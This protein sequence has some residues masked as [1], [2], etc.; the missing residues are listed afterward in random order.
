[1]LYYS[2]RYDESLVALKRA[3]QIAPDKFG[4]VEG[5]NSNNYEV[6]NRYCEALAA[7]LKDMASEL[8][9]Q[10]INTFRSAFATGG[11][12]A[13]QESRVKFLLTHSVN[14]CR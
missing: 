8:S 5:W 11:W 12:K 4:F 10:D 14:E 6:Q 9:P 7:D 1:M 3:S 13:Y 2:R